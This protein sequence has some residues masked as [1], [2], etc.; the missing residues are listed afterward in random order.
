[1]EKEIEEESGVTLG[2]IF[3]TIFSQKW[4]ALIIA[5]VIT[6]AGT[7]GLYFWGKRSEVYSVS[8]VSNLPGSQ[9]S[10]SY[11]EFPDG[12]TLHYT[13]MV[14]LGNLEDVKNDGSGAFDS[15]DVKKMYEC[16]DI[17]V[18]CEIAEIVEGSK[19][20]SATYVLTAKSKYFKSDALARDFL[21]SVSN[22]PNEYLRKMKIDYTTALDASTETIMYDKQLDALQEQIS[23]LNE[24]YTGLINAYGGNFV[25]KDGRTLNYYKSKLQ[26]F[27]DIGDIS[28]LKTDA[29][30]NG[31]LK[32]DEET[33]G[34]NKNAKAKYE[35]EKYN[36]ERE[37]DIANDSLT[38]ALN[39]LSGKEENGD[40]SGEGTATGSGVGGVVMI[41]AQA[42]IALTNEIAR[43]DKELLEIDRFI[44]EGNINEEFDGQV[45]EV[46]NKVKDFTDE[47]A[48]I[49]STVYTTRS[50]VNYL[51]TN[52][53]SIDGGRS[54]LMSFII[55]FAVGVVLAAIVAYIVGWS[56]Q[57]KAEKNKPYVGVP[58]FSE[59]Q[60]QAALA[61]ETEEEEQKLLTVSD[62]VKSDD[63]AKSENK[64]KKK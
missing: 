9:N 51:N 49:S 59:V 54:V 6:V 47:F 28:R 15:I 52:V 22:Y 34:I 11:F 31:Y 10:A 14:S 32:I 8:F 26:S 61:A 4:L 30:K 62:L 44:N 20:Y 7:L 42:V 24:E 36:K 64:T 50:T 27:V 48:G 5:A 56:R 53:I 38:L 46:Y 39:K 55:S 16:G 19:E 18:T 17:Y 45:N 43:L 21:S 41:D 25:V 33:G 2:Y 12:Q 35:A 40:G 57:K 63:T 13:E 29:V 3:R 1:M 60:A 58:V 37:R 23:F